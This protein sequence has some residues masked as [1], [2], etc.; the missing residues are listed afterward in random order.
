MFIVNNKVILF[1]FTIGIELRTSFLLF[2]AN[3]SV[4]SGF[5]WYKI[6][7]KPLNIQKF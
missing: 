3:I 1:E 2:A 5:L 6:D 4:T 7:I